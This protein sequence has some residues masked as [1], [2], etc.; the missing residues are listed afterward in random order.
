MKS[1]CHRLNDFVLMLMA[2]TR[3]FLKAT[4]WYQ[5]L[6]SRFFCLRL[7]TESFIQQHAPIFF[8]SDPDPEP[9]SQGRVV[10][11]VCGDNA[12]WSKLDEHRG[13]GYHVSTLSALSFHSVP[14]K[15]LMGTPVY[16]EETFNVCDW[17]LWCQTALPVSSSTLGGHELLKKLFP[18]QH[19]HGPAL[20][21]W[22]Y[23]GDGLAR[24]LRG[25]RRQPTPW[26]LPWH[27]PAAGSPLSPGHRPNKHGKSEN[28]IEGLSIG[29]HSP[30]KAMSF[31]TLE[32]RTKISLRGSYSRCENICRTNSSIFW[33]AQPVLN[34]CV[35]GTSQVETKLLSNP[36]HSFAL[37]HHESTMPM[38]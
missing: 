26:T 17:P 16:I 25:H 11:V 9:V 7:E 8:I 19:L 35:L 22:K 28:A 29:L 1:L 2:L 12:S 38:I 15:V 31:Q 27:S 14:S 34:I 18:V 6:L 32:A 10:S 37:R 5:T 33:R 24:W 36:R 4:T 30:I 13:T 21:H 23:M 20:R 3:F